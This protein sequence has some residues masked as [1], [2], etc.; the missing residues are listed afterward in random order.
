MLYVCHPARVQPD[1]LVFELGRLPVKLK[2]LGEM[3]CNF[4]SQARLTSMA[5]NW[6]A[7]LVHDCCG[8]F[9]HL[10]KLGFVFQAGVSA[11]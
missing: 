11:A 6:D 3:A 1:G 10:F 9:L 8:V 2:A 7:D 4:D 5:G